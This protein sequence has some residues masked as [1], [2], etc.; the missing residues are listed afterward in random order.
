[1]A[2]FACVITLREVVM[3]IVRHMAESQGIKF[4][5]TAAG[6]IKMSSNR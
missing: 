4:V 1:M 3:T 5:A 6:K 2:S